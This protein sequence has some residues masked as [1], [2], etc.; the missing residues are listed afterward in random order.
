MVYYRGK[1][2]RKIIFSIV[3]SNTR[4]KSFFS[5]EIQLHNF[6]FTLRPRAEFTSL[7]AMVSWTRMYIREEEKASRPKTSWLNMKLFEPSIQFLQPHTSINTKRDW[8][9]HSDTTWK[10]EKRAPKKGK[11][12]QK[13]FPRHFYPV[14]WAKFFNPEKNAVLVQI[15][16]YNK[17]NTGGLKQRK[18]KWKLLFY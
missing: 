11:M 16:S 2:Y 9:R 5:C 13:I 15:R 6:L 10:D 14:L 1:S 17:N 7:S 18:M 4:R 3:Y 12:K 8:H